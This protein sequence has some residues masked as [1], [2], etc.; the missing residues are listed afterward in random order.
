MKASLGLFGVVPS[1][2]KRIVVGSG[3]FVSI[4]LT[5]ISCEAPINVQLPA[6]R[7]V[8][9]AAPSAKLA[10]AKRHAAVLQE[11]ANG[12]IGFKT[13]GEF[14]GLVRSL[15]VAAP[16]EELGTRRPIGLI[17]D[18]THIIAERVERGKTRC[19][20]FRFSNRNRPVDGDDGGAGHRMEGVVEP[21]DG[22]PVG[23][24]GTPAY[25]MRGLHRRLELIATE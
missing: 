13:D 20:A 14:V 7:Q 3:G 6:A 25:D 15:A 16:G 4:S 9:A 23:P 1:S 18:K 2:V 10:V 8:P 5:L 21:L 24:A 22:G 17:F 11:A 19:G 12:R